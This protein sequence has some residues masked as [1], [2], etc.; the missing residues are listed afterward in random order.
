[1]RILR[2]PSLSSLW[3]ASASGGLDVGLV[4]ACYAP[5]QV[6][7]LQDRPALDEEAYLFFPCWGRYYTPHHIHSRFL[8]QPAR[9]YPAL[10]LLYVGASRL[11][12]VL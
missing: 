12:G 7:L 6:C 1:M 11:L 5:A 4:E 2:F 9:R 3:K 8:V 10:V